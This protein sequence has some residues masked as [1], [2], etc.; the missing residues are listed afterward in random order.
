MKKT[1]VSLL[2]AC[3]VTQSVGISYALRPVSTTQGCAKK[4]A[5][6]LE[7]KTQELPASSKTSPAENVDYAKTEKLLWQVQYR[8]TDTIPLASIINEVYKDEAVLYIQNNRSGVCSG[9]CIH[10]YKHGAGRR[11][12]ASNP[13]TLDEIKKII[14]KAFAFNIRTIS[15]NGED[16]FDDWE[17]LITIARANVN[18][19]SKIPNML[20]YRFHI[21]TNGYAFINNLKNAEEKFQELK[22]TGISLRL[23]F[24][25]DTEKVEYLK[26]QYSWSE[27]E[28][29]TAMA[30]LIIAFKKKLLNSEVK[31]QN[32]SLAGQYM[33]NTNFI[34][35]LAEKV[36]ELS[37]AKKIWFGH[38]RGKRKVFSLDAGSRADNKKSRSWREK[39]QELLEKAERG[40]F[41]CDYGP[42]IDMATSTLS[43]CYIYSS[44]F[45]REISAANFKDTILLPFK[46]PLTRHLY[47]G[48]IKRG[49]AKCRE[50]LFACSL[51]PEYWDESFYF[52]QIDTKIASDS[53]LKTK[54]ALLFLLRDILLNHER[55]DNSLP[56]ASYL[57]SFPKELTP[58]LVD[59]EILTAYL[60]YID[61]LR[62]AKWMELDSV[63][64]GFF[65]FYYIW[66]DYKKD[67]ITN[68]DDLLQ[69][70]KNIC[71]RLV[72][73]QFLEELQRR[74]I[75]IGG[76][77]GPNSETYKLK[78]FFDE[79]ST[80]DI[81]DIF[82]WALVNQILAKY[83]T[84]ATPKIPTA[85]D[86]SLQGPTHLRIDSAA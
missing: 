83:H 46:H 61:E 69:R 31:I 10:C 33:K 47:M 37:P 6:K 64:H 18:G 12:Y 26:T 52:Q 7:K 41:S 44:N 34:I 8:D 4:I 49:L 29:I 22:D 20:N 71:K 60:R 50:I 74:A 24:S 86:I 5:G 9:S 11:Q 30:N 57:K 36:D 79:L 23:S 53:I 81:H 63:W 76:E 25:W 80:T 42:F 54:I 78:Y 38:N 28:V 65:N 55:G 85:G 66:S 16:S 3:F 77:F 59:E 82:R 17:S 75:E 68:A 40:S 67:E 27:D 84:T 19:K 73:K 48:G 14:Y 56:I 62:Y 70:V 32:T 45:G 58:V 1:L 15:L 39:F 43:N 13:M 21:F 2:I 51:E 72:G 35:K